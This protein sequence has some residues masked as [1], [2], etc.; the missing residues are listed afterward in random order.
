MGDRLFP[1]L[2]VL[3]AFG[4]AALTSRAADPLMQEGTVVSAGAGKLV[5]KDASGKEQ[6]HAVRSE[7]RIMVLG[8][9]GKLEDLKVGMPVRIATDPGGRVLSVATV[10]DRKVASAGERS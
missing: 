4:I 5:L 6:W 10:D 8:K 3:L 9:P 1:L 2:A 7:A